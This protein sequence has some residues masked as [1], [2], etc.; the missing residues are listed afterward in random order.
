MQAYK[1]HKKSK[2]ARMDSLAFYLVVPLIQ[3]L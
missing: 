1:M 2:A 3:S